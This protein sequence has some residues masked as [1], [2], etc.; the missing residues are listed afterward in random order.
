M[1]A[2]GCRS[3]APGKEFWASIHACSSTSRTPGRSSP[4]SPETIPKT[5]NSRDSDSAAAAGTPRGPRR[6]TIAPSR[7]PQPPSEIGNVVARV[8]TG[9]TTARSRRVTSIPRARPSRKA[10]NAKLRLETR[11]ATA[12]ARPQRDMTTRRVACAI[13][14][15]SCQ[16]GIPTRRTGA[17]SAISIAPSPAIPQ[18]NR[19][20]LSQIGGLYPV[21]AASIGAVPKAKARTARTM[22]IRSSRTL[23]ADARTPWPF[24]AAS[25]TRVPSAATEGSTWPI[26][27]AA[28]NRTAI[29]TGGARSPMPRSAIHQRSPPSAIARRNGVK[30]MRSF[31]PEAAATLARTPA[32]ST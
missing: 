5:P 27:A 19:A 26:T 23:C 8:T 29:R 28:E 6:S 12:S 32:R 2:G 9:M 4:G 15:R 24:R 11:L 20:A 14:A 1:R 7:T 31:G 30:A 22:N 18:A 10:E 13:S 17:R 3:K 21:C 25:Q 16:S